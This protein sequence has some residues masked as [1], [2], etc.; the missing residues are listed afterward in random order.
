[1]NGFF[2]QKS[3]VHKMY[4]EGNKYETKWREEWVHSVHAEA[5]TGKFKRYMYFV[6]RMFFIWIW[7]L[8]ISF[9]LSLSFIL[10]VTRW[11][12][13][14]RLSCKRE[15]YAMRAYAVQHIYLSRL[16]A[17]IHDRNEYATRKSEKKRFSPQ[18]QKKRAQVRW[19]KWNVSAQ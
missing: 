10:S 14:C 9:S 3:Y 11:G 13:M 5:H 15:K 16:D 2:I 18:A 7:M 4:I 19:S 6:V 12:F 17:C 8:W 1:M